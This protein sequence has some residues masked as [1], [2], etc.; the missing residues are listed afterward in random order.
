MVSCSNEYAHPEQGLVHSLMVRSSRVG[1]CE[2]NSFS[3]FSHGSKHHKVLNGKQETSSSS[4]CV[5]QFR[6][7]NRSRRGRFVLRGLGEDR[8]PSRLPIPTFLTSNQRVK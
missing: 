3:I 4:A 1:R 5:S 8:P 2:G 6:P 7:L